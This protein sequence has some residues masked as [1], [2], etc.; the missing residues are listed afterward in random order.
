M[1]QSSLVAARRAGTIFPRRRTA[2]RRGANGISRKATFDTESSVIMSAMAES[3][4]AHVTLSG[5]RVGKYLIAEESP[6][7][8][9]TLTPDTS[10]AAIRRRLGTKPMGSEEFELH[11]GA[12]PTDDEG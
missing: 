9:L 3:T 12:L 10:I 4:T 11:F 7:G 2:P 6:D 5:A 8:T 1:T